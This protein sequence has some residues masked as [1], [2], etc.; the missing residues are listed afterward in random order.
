MIFKRVSDIIMFEGE[1]CSSSTGVYLTFDLD[2]CHEKVL[3]D[4]LDLINK[5]KAKATLF[6]TNKLNC[7]DL[8]LNNPSLE[9]GIHP[10]FNPLIDGSCNPTDNAE[11]ITDDLLTLVPNARS[12][13]SHSLATS[14]RLTAM[15]SSK[16]LTHESNTKIPF[17]IPSISPFRHSSGMIICPLHWSDYSDRNFSF[18]TITLPNYFMVNFHPIHIFLNTENLDR[19]E[20][21]R[22]LHHK[23]D[24]LIKYRYEG[25]GARTRLLELLK[26][27]EPEPTA[28]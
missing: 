14:G 24:K 8:L 20:R 10:N 9:L 22:H 1:K 19:Y 13:R 25:E 26:L 18:K 28:K 12:I 4:S 17:T 27:A 11:K 5:Y 21:T 7:I 15:F 16:G 6:L 23:P 2:W 3:L